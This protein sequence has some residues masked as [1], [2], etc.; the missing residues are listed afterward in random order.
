[1]HFGGTGQEGHC[2][3]WLFTGHGDFHLLFSCYVPFVPCIGNKEKMCFAPSKSSINHWGRKEERRK[4]KGGQEKLK[5]GENENDGV[6]V[7]SHDRWLRWVSRGL[8]PIVNQEASFW[9]H[10]FSLILLAT[11]W[12]MNPHSISEAISK[13]LTHRDT[14]W[15]NG[16]VGVP[17]PKWLM[18]KS[19]LFPLFC[20]DSQWQCHWALAENN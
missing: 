7:I 16:R 8:Y 3:K 10:I 17:T 19:K 13:T 4:R 1:M 6:Q 15:V 5:E 11:L 20:I 14:Q 9:T 2:S 12:C 18:P